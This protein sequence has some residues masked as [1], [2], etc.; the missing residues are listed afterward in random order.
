MK[1]ERLRIRSDQP[2]AWERL[3]EIHDSARKIEWT[4]AGLDGAF[5]PL[6]EAADREGLFDD[7][8]CAGSRP[9]HKRRVWKYN[10]G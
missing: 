3:T 6:S 10:G 8:V 9:E 7:T 5:L 4:L 2:Q 1:L